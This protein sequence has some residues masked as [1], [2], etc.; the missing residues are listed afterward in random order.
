MHTPAAACST[1]HI[2]VAWRVQ[3]VRAEYK[4]DCPCKAVLCS[5]ASPPQNWGSFTEAPV[6]MDPNFEIDPNLEIELGKLHRSPSSK[7]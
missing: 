5:V 4:R 2:R 3:V 7:S 1:G 6:K